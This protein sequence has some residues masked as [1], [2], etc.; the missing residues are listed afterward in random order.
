MCLCFFASSFS[1]G[2][3]SIQ[4]T[5]NNDKRFAF[6]APFSSLSQSISHKYKVFFH[7]H[8]KSIDHH[9]ACDN[10]VEVL[11]A[12]GVEDDED[13]DDVILWIQILHP[14]DDFQSEQR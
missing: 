4:Q 5:P 12:H 11:Q 7:T 10:V 2:T 3:S 1:K 8:T 6:F 14:V 9:D 13:P